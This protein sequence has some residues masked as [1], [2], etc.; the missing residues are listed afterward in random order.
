MSFRD[1]G[2]AGGAALDRP[3]DGDSYQVRHRRVTILA[4]RQNF[5]PLSRPNFRV[6]VS[7]TPLEISRPGEAR[8]QRNV[9]KSGLSSRG[10]FERWRTE[11]IR[12]HQ[13]HHLFHQALQ[14]VSNEFMRKPAQ[15]TSTL[16]MSK[17]A[18]L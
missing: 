8:A 1:L 5:R 15:R 9:L 4:D 18:W 6:E 3:R 13:G 12:F 11:L 7:Y 16:A 14:A 17:G 2:S 10:S